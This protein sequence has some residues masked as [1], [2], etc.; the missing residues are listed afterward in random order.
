MGTEPEPYLQDKYM[1]T[2]QEGRPLGWFFC[3]MGNS[4]E[5]NHGS[6]AKRNEKARRENRYGNRL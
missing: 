5:K 6:K 3:F 1:K 2:Q 4:Y